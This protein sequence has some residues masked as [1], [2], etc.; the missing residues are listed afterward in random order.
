MNCGCL[1]Q[2]PIERFLCTINRRASQ[3]DVA[4]T[5]AALRQRARKA[6]QDLDKLAG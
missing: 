3:Q 6:M 5:V 1:R 2:E 4:K